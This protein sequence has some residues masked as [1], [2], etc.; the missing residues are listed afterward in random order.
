LH[1]VASIYQGL[2]MRCTLRNLALATV[3]A[4]AIAPQLVEGQ[5]LPES[6]RAAGSSPLLTTNRTL[7][8]SLKRISQ[9][10]RLWR[11]A[12]EAV[13][14]TGRHVL[15][16]TPGDV[17]MAGSEGRDRHGLAPGVLAEA[18][19]A[20]GEDSEVRLV[21][22][23]VNLR[24]VQ[25]IHNARLS[26]PRDVEA[27]LDRILV[28]EVYGHALPYLLAGDTS[29][30]CPDPRDGESA[31]EAC[32]IRRENAVRAEL[33]LGRREDSGIYSLALALGAR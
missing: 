4:C 29:G 20:I 27:D 5:S 14:R 23:V 7:Q 18:I 1:W 25:D 2:A 22:I 30:Q 32:S 13:R 28:H 15:V 9:G 17:T 21:V 24:L 6:G 11:E 16:V 8:A 33:G 10:S 31:S 19:P 12:V 26:A 3:M